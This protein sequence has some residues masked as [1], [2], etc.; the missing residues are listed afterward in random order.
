MEK[1][2]SGI[3]LPLILALISAKSGAL[4]IV[5][6]DGGYD[7]VLLK[8]KASPTIS[9]QASVRGREMQIFSLF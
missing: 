5:V 3:S 1:R 8:V 2:D 4:V 6:A 7:S 9:P